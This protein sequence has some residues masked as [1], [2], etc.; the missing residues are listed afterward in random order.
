M[1]GMVPGAWGDFN[2]ILHAFERSTGVSPGNAMAEFR[3]F[4]NQRALL[5]LLLRG[6]EFTWSRSGVD[7]TLPC[8]DRMGGALS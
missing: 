2:E 6:R 7:A 1:G 8:V 5:D 4:I 3:I